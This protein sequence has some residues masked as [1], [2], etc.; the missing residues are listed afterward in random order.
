[1][2]IKT[3]VATEIAL[4]AF[5]TVKS[6]GKWND[7]IGGEIDWSELEKLTISSDLD[8]LVKKFKID[9][10]EIEELI[11]DLDEVIDSE[12]EQLQKNEN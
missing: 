1:M 9:P 12:I 10:K 2:D 5:D 6:S 11:K 8:E 3:K 4:K 7:I